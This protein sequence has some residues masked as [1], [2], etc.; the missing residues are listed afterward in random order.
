MPVCLV[1]PFNN[2][3]DHS[4]SVMVLNYWSGCG[5]VTVVTVWYLSALTLILTEAV[6]LLSEIS[7]G[8][9]FIHWQTGL[10]SSFPH[11]FIFL[12][13]LLLL[14]SSVWTP[15]GGGRS[16]CWSAVRIRPSTRGSC[17]ASRSTAASC[18]WMTGRGR[19]AGGTT[20]LGTR[21]GLQKNRWVQTET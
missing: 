21:E 13:S 3:C 5:S 12:P 4:C 6:E 1:G 18:G 14:S 7:W 15:T 2:W 20:S 9:S 11:P 16:C 8:S 17:P 19:S 10:Y